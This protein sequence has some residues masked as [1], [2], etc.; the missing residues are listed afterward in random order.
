MRITH[1]VENLNRGGL[2]RVVIDLV[3]RQQASGHDCQVVCLFE[4]GQLAPQVERLGIPLAACGKGSGLD[5][6]A[7][8]RMR[9]AVRAHRPEVLHTHNAMAHYYAVLATAF[10]RLRRVNTRH[11]LANVPYSRRRE[12]L[13][14]AAM[15]FSDAGAVVCDK[16]RDFFVGQGII[17]EGKAVTVYN[18]IPVER[19][20]P[21]NAAA[22]ARLLAL[23]GW[24]EP[25]VVAGIVARLTV[26]KDHATL[27]Q[28]MA[29]AHAEAP[30]LRLVVVGDG[31]LRAAL[32]ARR[33]EL[34]L[35]GEVRFLGDRSDVGEL[36]AG[37][38]VFVLS[39][40]TEGYSISLLE[41]CAAALPVVATD[42]GGNGEIIRDGVNG[43]LVAPGAPRAFADAMVRLARDPALREQVAQRALR[44]A[45]EQASVEAMAERYLALYRKAA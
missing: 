24:A 9:A 1:V 39:S 6:R 36:L 29:L 27:L 2:E 17:P 22:R 32:E 8:A 12:A 3:E 28:A 33:A 16:A 23:A 40:I 30:Q 43:L 14:K 13:Y 31:P 15:R 19:F 7:L 35:G 45:R 5:L 18:G 34:G 10:M 4:P 44:F 20:A 26:A 41:A 11:G 25:C 21:R 38:D 37:L 42:V